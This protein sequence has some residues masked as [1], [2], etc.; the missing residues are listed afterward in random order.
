M[1]KSV[2]ATKKRNSIYDFIKSVK[3]TKEI[4][5]IIRK[6]GRVKADSLGGFKYDRKSIYCQVLAKKADKYLV[7]YLRPYPFPY[8]F[9]REWVPDSSVEVFGNN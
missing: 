2:T 5:T 7:E 6:K 4:V 9:F 3:L 8:K 1:L